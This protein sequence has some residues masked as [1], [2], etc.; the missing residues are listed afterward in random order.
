MTFD[1]SYGLE[2]YQFNDFFIILEVM[3]LQVTEDLLRLLATHL[4]TSP[5]SI[6]L[7]V[8]QVKEILAL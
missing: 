8:I 7:V 3:V 5:I 4:P 2:N 6:L 1:F